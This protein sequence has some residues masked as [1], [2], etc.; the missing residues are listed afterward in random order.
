MFGEFDNRATTIILVGIDNRREERNAIRE[1][2]QVIN[3]WYDNIRLCTA[4]RYP[5]FPFNGILFILYYHQ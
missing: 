1:K 3:T 5:D 2:F 4:G